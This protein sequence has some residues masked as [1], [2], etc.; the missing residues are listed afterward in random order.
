M[1]KENTEALLDASKEV[2]LEVSTKKT[3]NSFMSRHL[4]IGRQYYLMIAGKSS[5]NVKFFNDRNRAKLPSRRM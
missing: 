4:I 3:K 2:G 1:P 5:E